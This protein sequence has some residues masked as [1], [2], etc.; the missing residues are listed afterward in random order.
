M[1]TT[2]PPDDEADD[3]EMLYRRIRAEDPDGPSAKT[4][5]AILGHSA[6]LVGSRKQSPDAGSTR[7]PQISHSLGST[8]QVGRLSPPSWRRPVLV[9]S[10]AAAALGCLLIGPQH[11]RPVARPKV[12]REVGTAP[13]PAER[14]PT[15]VD[16]PHS[17]PTPQS[18]STPVEAPPLPEVAQ[19][20]AVRKP[21]LLAASPSQVT[22]VPAAAAPSSINQ[23]AAESRAAAPEGSLPARSNEDRDEVVTVTGSRRGAPSHGVSTGGTQGKNLADANTADAAIVNMRDSEGRTPLMLAVLQNRLDAVEDLLHRHAD[24][25]VADGA[26]V[27]PLQAALAH[28][29]TEI[30]AALRHAGAH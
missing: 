13:L 23:A 6:R 12:A 21:S 1:N 10:L 9:G 19:T 7:P 14:R 2:P 8:T 26:G 25:N 15:S 18:V 28:N 30:A 3:L 4:R 27:T 17:A 5:Q 16:V 22:P 29:E 11:L 20:R 24:P